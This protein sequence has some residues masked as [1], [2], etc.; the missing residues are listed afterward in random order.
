[1]LSG[2]EDSRTNFKK[3]TEL[4]RTRKKAKK[5]KKESYSAREKET[6]RDEG[7]PDYIDVSRHMDVCMSIHVYIA[8]AVQTGSRYDDAPQ[9]GRLRFS[10]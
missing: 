4:R 7:V 2:K 8:R 6:E 9:I 3:K 10:P 5:R 1:M